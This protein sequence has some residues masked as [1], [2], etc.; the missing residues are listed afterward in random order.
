MN[1]KVAV[2]DL[3]TIGTLTYHIFVEKTLD[4]W[5]KAQIVGTQ[6]QYTF[7]VEKTKEILYFLVK[8]KFI[9]FPKDHQITNK[10]ELRGKT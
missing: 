1:K 7:E 10:D 5:N 4:L 8:Q 9:T 2:V 6:V 3:S